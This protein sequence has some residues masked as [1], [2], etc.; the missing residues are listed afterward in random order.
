MHKNLRICAAAAG[1]A[2]ALAVTGC[3]SDSSTTDKKAAGSPAA[4]A[5]AGTTGSTGGDTKGGS[6]EGGWV[7]MANP[8][9]AVILTV[10]G[11]IAI[12]IEA[13]TGETCQGTTDGKT[14]ETTC[15]KGGTRTKGH[16]DSVDATSLK[17]TWDGA[18]TDT[19]EKS[20]AGKLPTGMPKR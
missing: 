17:V 10:N 11:K 18:G 13:A 6:L 9:K 20:E 3:S 16:V 5:A 19:F 14:I 8:G 2:A 1:L 7:S 4:G 15:P 12:V